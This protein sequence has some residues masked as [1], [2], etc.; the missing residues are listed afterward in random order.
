MGVQCG[1]EVYELFKVGD[2]DGLLI[3]YC[4]KGYEVDEDNDVWIL[5]KLDLMEVLVVSIG[6]N[7]NVIVVFVKLECWLYEI[8][9]KFWVGDWFLEWEFEDFLKGV[10]SFLNLQ[11]ECVVCVYLK[12]QGEFD[13]VVMGFVFLQV[14]MG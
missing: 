12:G 8:M 13:D 2:I 14:F 9:E 3:G 7:E 10:F 5:I 4:I 6:V 11:V 1:C